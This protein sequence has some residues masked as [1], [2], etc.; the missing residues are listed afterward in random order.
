MYSWHLLWGILISSFHSR[1][2]SHSWFQMPFHSC[3]VSISFLANFISFTHG[4]YFILPWH[5]FYSLVACISFSHC[6][7][8][9]CHFSHPFLGTCEVYEFFDLGVP[10]WYHPIP[11]YGNVIPYLGNVIPNVIPYLGNV[12]PY[13]GNEIIEKSCDLILMKQLRLYT[14]KTI[15]TTCS[16][17]WI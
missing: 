12:I 4:I 15:L 11:W 8:F 6:I 2:I 14:G 9:I 17:Y 10:Q 7:Y 3:T 16:M 5:L 1:W 13:H